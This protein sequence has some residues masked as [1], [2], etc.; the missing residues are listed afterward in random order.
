[1]FAKGA[2]AAVGLVA[3][4][5]AAEAKTVVFDFAAQGWQSGGA[6]NYTVDDLTLEITA[7]NYDTPETVG[8]PLDTNFGLPILR[9]AGYGLYVTYWGDNDHRIDGIINEVVSFAFNKVVTITNVTFG[10]VKDG[11][12]F[13]LFVDG[14]YTRSAGVD[15]ASFDETGSTFGIGASFDEWVKVCKTEDKK[16]SSNDKHSKHDKK[17]KEKCDWV[18]DYSAFKITSLTVTYDDPPPPSEV[19]LPAAGFL[20]LGAMGGLAAL[21]RRKA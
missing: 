1:M 3:A 14:T 4:V 11:S 6:L 20:L 9:S 16:Q 5:S 13:D 12:L 19:P 7:N 2:I 15:G 8:E 17:P 18:Y 21:R 10:S